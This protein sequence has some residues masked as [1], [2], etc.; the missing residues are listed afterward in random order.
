[1]QSLPTTILFPQTP[2]SPLASRYST[3]PSRQLESFHQN[4]QARVYKLELGED[5]ILATFGHEVTNTSLSQCHSDRM[6]ASASAKATISPLGLA[7]EALGAT[8]PL[9]QVCIILF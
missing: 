8:T 2:L 1:L 6:P 5:N 4:P 3:K 7:L 9:I